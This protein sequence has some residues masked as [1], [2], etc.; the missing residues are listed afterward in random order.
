[1]SKSERPF[2]PLNVAILTVSDT[3]TPETD[4]SGDTIA[5]KL[6]AAGHRV[7]ARA[8]LKDDID[9]LRAQVKNWI[10]DPKIDAVISTGGTG[11]THRDVTPEALTPL[12]SKPIPGFGELFRHLSYAEIGSS[13]I[14]SRAFAGIGTGGT[15]LFCLP[16]STG[17]CKLGMDK[18]ILEQ[19]DSRYKPCNLVALLPR[20]K[21]EHAPH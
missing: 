20:I 8:I 3:R 1:M 16:G 19:L 10:D 14:E 15:I 7:A 13:T 17:A 9:K 5:E 11:L 6:T 21:H 18:I 4:S 12:I 2:I